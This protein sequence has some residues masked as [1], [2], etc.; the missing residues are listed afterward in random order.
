MEYKQF[1]T[2]QNVSLTELQ[3]KHNLNKSLLNSSIN[4]LKSSK[5]EHTENLKKNKVENVKSN[6]KLNS[7]VNELINKTN[8]LVK[9]KI[10]EKTTTN[11]EKTIEDKKETKENIVSSKKEIASSEKNSENTSNKTFIVKTDIKTE[12]NKFGKIMPI[13]FTIIAI[14][15]SG[16]LIY[17]KQV[18]V[19]TLLLLSLVVSLTIICHCSV[20]NFCIFDIGKTI[21]TRTKLGQ[22]CNYTKKMYFT[23]LLCGFFV[24]YIIFSYDIII[25]LIGTIKTYIRNF[26]LK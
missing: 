9:K 7:K 12:P 16:L 14:I 3:K 6:S 4:E 10:I 5:K 18:S 22:R 2:F 15:C 20:G 21:W 26:F 23:A 17:T 25:S 1:E 8:K 19:Y 11:E 24:S 13:G